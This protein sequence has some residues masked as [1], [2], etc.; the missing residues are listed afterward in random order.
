MVTSSA[1]NV[2]RW[3][4]VLIFLVKIKY[5]QFLMQVIGHT[6]FNLIATS[7]QKNIGF[8]QFILAKFHLFK[9]LFLENPHSKYLNKYFLKYLSIIITNLLFL[10]LMENRLIILNGKIKQSIASKKNFNS[11]FLQHVKLENKNLLT[12]Y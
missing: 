8:V 5:P 2:C 12:K 1:K 10:L 3:T 7:N 4:Y 11:P 9:S 6:T